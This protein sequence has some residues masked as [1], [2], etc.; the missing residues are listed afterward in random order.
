VADKSG[1]KGKKGGVSCGKFLPETFH[2]LLKEIRCE[3]FAKDF[4]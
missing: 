2:E 1:E 3:L 4:P